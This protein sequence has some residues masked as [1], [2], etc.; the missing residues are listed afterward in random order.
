M[1]RV[2]N[3]TIGFQE[4]LLETKR[5]ADVALAKLNKLYGKQTYMVQEKQ[6]PYHSLTEVLALA[7]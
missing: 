1:P 5:A 2:D 3:D 7:C 4:H 6:G